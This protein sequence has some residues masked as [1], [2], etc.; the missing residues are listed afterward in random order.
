MTTTLTPPPVR[1][2]TEL[3]QRLQLRAEDVE[4]LMLES[5]RLGVVV[6]VRGGWKLSA[7]AEA[8]LGWLCEG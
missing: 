5:E 2:T 1:T 3:A 4:R 6:R 8:R 7:E